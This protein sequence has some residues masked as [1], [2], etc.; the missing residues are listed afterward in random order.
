MFCGALSSWWVMVTNILELTVFILY[1]GPLPITGS[2]SSLITYLI[3]L[4]LVLF[5]LNSPSVSSFQLSNYI[6][7]F[8]FK[9]PLS[10]SIS[11]KQKLSCLTALLKLTEVGIATKNF[12]GIQNSQKEMPDVR[13]TEEYHCIFITCGVLSCNITWHCKN[14]SRK[15]FL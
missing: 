2:M 9:N 12:Q 10:L 15:Y 6:S 7:S 13:N 14:Y 1:I 5:F 8:I 4:H 3:Q 11:V